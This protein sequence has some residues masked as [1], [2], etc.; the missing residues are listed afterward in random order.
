MNTSELIQ[1]YY[2]CFNAADWEGM[3]ELL[4]D[5]VAHDVNESNREGGKQ[6]FRAFLARMNRSYREQIDPLEVMVNQDGTR[7]AAEYV[8]SGRYQATDAGL[9]EARGQSYSLPGGAFFTV[10]DGKIARV[11]NYYN[12][13]DWLN[14]IA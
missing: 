1:N 13:Q 4:T 2:A 5:D 9:P 6:T 7:A 8:V 11:T 10:R 12:L 3:L 14:Q